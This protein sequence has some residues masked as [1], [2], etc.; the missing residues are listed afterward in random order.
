MRIFLTGAS[1]LVGGAVARIAAAHGHHI[2]G[3]VG[4]FSER[5]AG[6][7]EQVSLELLDESALRKAVHDAKPEAIINCAA[8]S[9][10]AD[11][12]AEPERA[13]KLNVDLPAALAHLTRELDAR[14]V[15]VSTEQVFGG[16][17][18]PYHRE[19]PIAPINLYGRQKAAG[20]RVVHDTA[21]AHAATVRAP[22]LT[23][24]SPTGRRSL[25]ERLLADW[26][27]GRTPRL[28]TDEIR[29]V[30]HADNLA[31]VLLE[32]CTRNDLCGVY[33]W[34]GA[35]PLSRYELGLRIREH[36]R[37][38]PAHAPIVAVSRTENPAAC[39]T[40]P[41]DL[42]LELQPLVDMLATKPETFAQQLA[43]MHVPAPCRDWLGSFLHRS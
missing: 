17:R 40:R 15:H 21:P 34:A 30:A 6:L 5:V 27:N 7:T 26:M 39:R 38:S 23:G 36:F 2:V 19:D 18:A 11:C 31:R 14:F 29:Q 37:L 16:D 42:R 1:G 43:Q 8:I 10:P 35:E 3:T 41:A 33:H 24:N 28:F 13:Q 20:E 9:E 22:L 25:H 32:L 12:E 4:R